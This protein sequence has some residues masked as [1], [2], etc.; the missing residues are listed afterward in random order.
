MSLSNFGLFIILIA[1]LW[2]LWAFLRR[3]QKIQLGFLLLYAI[4][5][6]MLVWNDL[7]FGEFGAA[8][9]LNLADVVIVVVLMFMAKK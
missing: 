4:G 8:A 5:A 1:W 6:V 2:Q 9:W 7:I 3:K